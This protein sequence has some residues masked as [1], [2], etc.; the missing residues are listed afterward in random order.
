M[1]IQT[2]QANPLPPCTTLCCDNLLAGI[3]VVEAVGALPIIR[4]PTLGPGPPAAG[5]PRRGRANRWRGLP[6]RRRRTWHCGTLRSP[7][8]VVRAIQLG[9]EVVLSTDGTYPIACAKA[10][11]TKHLVLRAPSCWLGGQLFIV[12]VIGPLPGSLDTPTFRH[13]WP[14]RACLSLELRGRCDS[15]SERPASRRMRPPHTPTFRHHHPWHWRAC[16]LS[17]RSPPRRGRCGDGRMRRRM[18]PQS[19][20]MMKM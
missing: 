18:R 13:P 1:S 6:L 9:R 17:V 5:T 16:L 11:S 14:W 10:F 2:S 7:A 3:V 20:T 8:P 12:T 19:D 15:L 4:L